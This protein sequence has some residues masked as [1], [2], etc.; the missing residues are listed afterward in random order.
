MPE[1]EWS[2]C[3]LCGTSRLTY[4]MAYLTIDA[5]TNSGGIRRDFPM[6]CPIC[7]EKVVT[8]AHIL[9]EED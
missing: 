7:V 1:P 5:T 6:V 8:Y 4:S 3:V 2:E 9:K